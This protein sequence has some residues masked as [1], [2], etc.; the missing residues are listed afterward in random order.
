MLLMQMKED[1]L[2]YMEKTIHAHCILSE[3]C[4]QPTNTLENTLK[5]KQKRK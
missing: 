4:Q 5:Q 1:F 3:L 2:K